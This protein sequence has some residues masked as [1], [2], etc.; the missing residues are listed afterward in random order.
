MPDLIH[1]TRS[2][3]ECDRLACDERQ[4]E[5][6]RQA[7]QKERH[8]VYDTSLNPLRK[9]AQEHYLK[10]IALNDRENEINRTMAE[11]IREKEQLWEDREKEKALY[12][13]ASGELVQKI[14]NVA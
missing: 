8:T 5:S 4:R 12:E 14:N 2:P 10:V 7:E 13:E 1:S 9:T 3:H 11:L 6:D